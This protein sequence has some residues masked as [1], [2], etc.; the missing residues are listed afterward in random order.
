MTRAFAC[1][2][3]LVDEH[4]GRF[5]LSGDLVHVHAERLLGAVGE[6]LDHHGGL[7]QLRIDCGD[8]AVCDSRGLSVLLTM[9]EVSAEGFGAKVRDWNRRAELVRWREAWAERVNE[10]LAEL[11]HD[12]RVDHRT[13]AEQGLPLEPQGSPARILRMLRHRLTGR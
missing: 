12:M 9:R 2:W 3:E 7:R 13:L 4:T 10:Q 1:T 6:R 11:G 5:A 8:L